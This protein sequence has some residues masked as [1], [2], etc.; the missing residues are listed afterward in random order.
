M[1]LLTT[2][3]I[4]L[5]FALQ[6]QKLSDYQQQAVENNPSLLAAYK[7]FEADLTKVQQVNNFTDPTL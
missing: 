7:Q 1:K 6:G 2:L 4:L 5:S 3:L